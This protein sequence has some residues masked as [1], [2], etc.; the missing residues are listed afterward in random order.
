LGQ[1]PS[2]AAN[3]LVGLHGNTL[4]LGKPG[5][6]VVDFSSSALPRH[7][8]RPGAEDRLGRPESHHIQ[9]GT[10]GGARCLL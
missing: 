8:L 7:P 5:D 2:S 3:P 4:F 1:T 10:A 6:F 9:S